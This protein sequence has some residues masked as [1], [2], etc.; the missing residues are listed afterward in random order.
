MLFK[1]DIS[2]IYVSVRSAQLGHEQVRWVRLTFLRNFRSYE[3]PGLT[4]LRLQQHMLIQ[5]LQLEFDSL[6]I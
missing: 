3:P 2:Y 1:T 4:F 5:P 6:E